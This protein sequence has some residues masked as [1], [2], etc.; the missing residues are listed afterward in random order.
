MNNIGRPIAADA[1]DYC[2]YFFELTTEDNLLDS[3]ENSKNMTMDIIKSVPVL[4]EEYR[5]AEGKWTIKMVFSHV[6][7]CERHY[8]YFAM[9]RS[10]HGS[11]HHV[12]LERDLYALNANTET[13]SLRDIGEEFLLVRESTIRLFR[14]MN[15]EM[16]DYKLSTDNTIYTPR[17]L[18]W[19]ASGHTVHH[20]KFIKEK[21][22]S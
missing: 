2:R 11:V 19:M 6:I 16:L 5:Y 10:R 1:P 9:C 22:L 15:D 13:R 12:E 3:L 4:K 7:D 20:C 18:G 14:T 17:S 21:Y 8:S